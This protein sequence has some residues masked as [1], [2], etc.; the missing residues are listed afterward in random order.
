MDGLTT[1]QAEGVQGIH[2]HECNHS[3]KTFAINP[4]LPNPMSRPDWV[5]GLLLFLE[6]GVFSHR[7][8]GSESSTEYGSIHIFNQVPKDWG[9]KKI[10]LPN[11]PQ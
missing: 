11:V 10:L 7:D 2:Q 9:Y 5:S 6:G 3:I 1:F 4:K 8:I